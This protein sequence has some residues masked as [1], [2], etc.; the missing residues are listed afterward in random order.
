MRWSDY[1]LLRLNLLAARTPFN[2]LCLHL[3]KTVVAPFGSHRG[4]QLF[5]GQEEARRSMKAEKSSGLYWGM[6][7]TLLGNAHVKLTVTG[8]RRLRQNTKPPLDSL[9]F[10]YFSVHLVSSANFVNVLGSSSQK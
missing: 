10:P 1:Q 7:M 2:I 8:H 3:D 5:R 6:Q 4:L 9:R